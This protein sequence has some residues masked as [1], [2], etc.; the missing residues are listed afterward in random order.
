MQVDIDLDEG[1]LQQVVG[2]VRSAEPLDE[3]AVDRV[4]VTVEEVL[5]GVVVALQ[6][7]SDQLAVRGYDI[8][9]YLHTRSSR[10]SSSS[11]SAAA[12]NGLNRS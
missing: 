11:P 12:H 10:R 1:L 7:P 2:V 5:E 9:V 3:Q 4:A 8:V 6:H